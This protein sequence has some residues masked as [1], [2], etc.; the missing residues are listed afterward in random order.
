MLNISL[1]LPLSL[2]MVGVVTHCRALADPALAAQHKQEY[3][4]TLE[5]FN[6]RVREF[7]PPGRHWWVGPLELAAPITATEAHSAFWKLNLSSAAGVDL[8][9]AELAAQ[10]LYIFLPFVVSFFNALLVKGIWT[11]LWAISQ[12]AVFPAPQPWTR[13]PQT[14]ISKTK[15]SP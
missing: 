3:L 7:E 1:V 12:I 11:A 13:A 15:L 4:T 8:V 10:L 5:V 2:V 14:L 6:S 9:D